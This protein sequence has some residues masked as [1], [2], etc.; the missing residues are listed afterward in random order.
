M[1]SP[2]RPAGSELALDRRSGRR[3]QARHR[4][5]QLRR[6]RVRAA[7]RSQGVSAAGGTLTGAPSLF[8][9]SA[10]FEFW[11][12]AAYNLLSSGP[13]ALSLVVAK[14]IFGAGLINQC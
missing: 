10:Q 8:S 14:L 6:I 7:G 4:A 2:A 3:R 11:N 12:D 5:R 1:D 13:A 9:P